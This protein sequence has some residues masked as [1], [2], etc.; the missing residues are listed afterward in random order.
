ME[1]SDRWVNVRCYLVPKVNEA[2]GM[3]VLQ[4]YPLCLRRGKD[5]AFDAVASPFRTR[6]AMGRG[7]RFS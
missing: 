5:L 6:R 4:K 3:V 7:G 1:A 2:F